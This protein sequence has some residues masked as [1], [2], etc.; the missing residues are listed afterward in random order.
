MCG[1]QPGV[2][3]REQH[4]GQLGGR[5]DPGS[6]T[7]CGPRLHPGRRFGPAFLLGTHLTQPHPEAPWAPG[8]CKGLG[9]NCKFNACRC[10]EDLGVCG[11]EGG[12]SSQPSGC[13]WQK[14][15]RHQ[16]RIQLLAGSSKELLQQKVPAGSLGCSGSSPHLRAGQEE[17][18]QPDVCMKPR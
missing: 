18:Q 17:D 9:W 3:W 14:P 11:G 7:Q 12:R 10:L 6:T 5:S 4:A 1:S 8:A 13:L 15:L 16:A 2:E